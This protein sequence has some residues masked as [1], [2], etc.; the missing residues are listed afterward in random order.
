MI[1][2]DQKFSVFRLKQIIEGLAWTEH[3]LTFIISL[4]VFQTSP[5]HLQQSLKKILKNPLGSK[6]WVW[7]G[8]LLWPRAVFTIQVI[9]LSVDNCIISQHE[10]HLCCQCSPIS[11]PCGPLYVHSV[12]ERWEAFNIFFPYCLFNIE[13]WV[14]LQY[15]NFRCQVYSVDHPQY[16][17]RAN[18]HDR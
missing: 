13:V 12:E 2:H 1:R 10:S 9:I 4:I 11:R 15:N 14:T 6:K 17:I 5:S 8:F 7:I 3:I 18:S 16:S